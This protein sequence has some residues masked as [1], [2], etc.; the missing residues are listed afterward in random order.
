MWYSLYME[1]ER[2][3]P[4]IQVS[5]IREVI[6]ESEKDAKEI[7]EEMDSFISDLKFLIEDL[8]FRT[9][10][11]EHMESNNE[12]TEEYTE[13]MGHAPTLKQYSQEEIQETKDKALDYQNLC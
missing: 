13:I 1:N 4:I 8:E 7:Q 6:N 2:N 11:L 9:G 12:F 10:Y 3:K 5:E